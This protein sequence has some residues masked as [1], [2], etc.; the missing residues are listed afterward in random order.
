MNIADEPQSNK[1]THSKPLITQPIYRDA[2]N[3]IYKK[4]QRFVIGT[5]YLISGI[6]YIYY[7][8]HLISI[9]L[10]LYNL[11]MSRSEYINQPPLYGGSLI[12]NYLFLLGF[13]LQYGN[14]PNL[15]CQLSFL[16]VPLIVINGIMSVLIS[17]R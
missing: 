2:R 11:T 3:T 12:L 17:V 1:I 14:Q 5:V 4:F 16:F 6:L 10:K 9:P 8:G 7:I 13:N 15:W